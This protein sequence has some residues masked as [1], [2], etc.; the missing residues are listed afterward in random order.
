MLQVASAPMSEQHCKAMLQPEVSARVNF[1]SA[2]FQSCLACFEHM[3]I[4]IRIHSLPGSLL[5]VGKELHL[6]TQPYPAFLSKWWFPYQNAYAMRWHVR[7]ILLKVFREHTKL[8]S[9]HTSV[10]NLVADIEKFDTS[11]VAK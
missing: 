1:A 2:E 8:S 6:H 3:P 10:V 4:V 11:A 9:D 5:T 7:Q